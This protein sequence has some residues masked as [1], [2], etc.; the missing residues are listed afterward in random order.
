MEG[1]ASLETQRVLEVFKRTKLR[2]NST[3]PFH[4]RI[5]RFKATDTHV[6]QCQKVNS[7]LVSESLGWKMLP[8]IV[9]ALNPKSGSV[10]TLAFMLSSF[11]VEVVGF[12]K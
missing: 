7:S 10:E 8:V 4:G 2:C 6:S 1:A 9:T 11:R 3:D 12:Q 5:K